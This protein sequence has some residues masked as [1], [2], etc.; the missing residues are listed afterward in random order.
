MITIPAQDIKRRGIGAVDSL[1]VNEP[2]HIIKNNLPQYVVLRE[3][4]YQVMMEDLALAR[5]ESSEA[6]LQAGRIRKGSASDL[7]KELNEPE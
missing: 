3:E 4:D 7:L 6:D 5:I 1:I 2:V